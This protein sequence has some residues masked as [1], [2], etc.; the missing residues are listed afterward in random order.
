MDLY[1]MEL[2]KICHRKILWII[3]GIM[4][5][6]LGAWFHIEIVTSEQTTINGETFYGYGAIQKDRE[7]SK[8]FE[9]ILTDRETEK[10][11]DKYGLPKERDMYHGVWPDENYLNG[12]VAEYLSDA[13]PGTGENAQRAEHLNLL[14]ESFL[15]SYL[16]H[17]ENG[18]FFGYVNGW[19]K[20]LQFFQIVMLSV[21]AWLIIALTPIFCE[22]H[23]VKMQPLMFTTDRGKGAD[24]RAKTGAAFTVSLAAFFAGFILTFAACGIVYGFGG[25]KMATGILY[26]ATTSSGLGKISIA[27]YTGFYLVKVICAVLFLTM[28]MISISSKMKTTFQTAIIAG[29][30]WFV[31]VMLEGMFRGGGM[32]PAY[33]LVSIQP[34]L[35]IVTRCITETWDVYGYQIITVCLVVIIGTWL[36]G[37]HWKKVDTE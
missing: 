3:G 5:L 6:W 4:F 10:I 20:F 24:V 19:R 11:I 30:I 26:V 21:S 14:E 37:M 31:P 34:V 32:N 23:Q 13:Y 16:Q 18:I 35:L 28:L 33:F 22:E 9:G 1:R 25:S 8:E 17:P 7:I 15:H 12:F 2:Y 29:M 27:A 36:A